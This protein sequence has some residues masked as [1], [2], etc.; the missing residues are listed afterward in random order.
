MS[1][2]RRTPIDSGRSVA[3]FTVAAVAVLPLF[4]TSTASRGSLEAQGAGVT[5]SP[6]PTATQ[7]DAND[8]TLVPIEVEICYDDPTTGA[9]TCETKT[10]YFEAP[11]PPTAG[12]DI[13]NECYPEVQISQLGSSVDVGASDAFRVKVR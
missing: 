8:K 4:W 13:G 12:C 7:A 11:E 1:F 5:A 10:E 9:E 3:L 6:T 2:E